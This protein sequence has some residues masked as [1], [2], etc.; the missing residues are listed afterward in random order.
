MLLLCL[1]APAFSEPVCNVDSG[2]GKQLNLPIYEWIDSSVPTKGIVVA[3]HGLTFYATA[4]DQLARRLAS[5]GYPFYAPDLRGFGRWKEENAKFGG[6]DKIHFTQSEEDVTRIAQ[7][8]RT[9]H[10]NTNI[11]CLGESLG[12]NVA[13]WLAAEHPNVID[14]TVLSAPGVKNCI[15]PCLR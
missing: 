4:Y 3:V 6:D 13:L 1:A 9:A 7:A 11:L 8:L 15:H 2:V 5:E 14:A 10:P 12:A